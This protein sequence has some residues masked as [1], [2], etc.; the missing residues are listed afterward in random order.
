MHSQRSLLAFC[1]SFLDIPIVVDIKIQFEDSII[2][3]FA[4]AS[5][6]WPVLLAREHVHDWHDHLE[7]APFTH[8][9]GCMLQGCYSC[10]GFEQDMRGCKVFKANKE[11]AS[12]QEGHHTRI[13]AA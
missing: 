11:I 6:T 1:T 2:G 8:E 7:V 4:T 13:D 3:M 5:A 10:H 9:P 12:R